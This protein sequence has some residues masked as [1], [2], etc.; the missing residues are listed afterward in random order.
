LKTFRFS[1]KYV[2]FSLDPVRIQGHLDREEGQMFTLLRNRLGIPGII[3][4]TALVLAMAGGA[5]A[6]KSVIITKLSQIAPGV[7]KQLKKPGPPGTPGAPGAPGAKGDSGVAGP[8]GDPGAPGIGTPGAAGKSVSVTDVSAGEPECGGRG[9]AILEQEGNPASASE[10]C[11]GE[12]GSPWTAGGT[13]PAGATETGVWSPTS[14]GGLIKEGETYFQISF[15]LPLANAPD[16][17]AVK[18]GEDKSAEGCPGVVDGVPTADSGKL[19]VYLA[20]GFHKANLTFYALD[21][22]ASFESEATAPPGIILDVNCSGAGC[23]AW[24]TWA[25]TG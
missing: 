9:G 21:P 5:Y 12:E 22:T 1:F 13:L 3:S 23:L 6:S 15:T 19:C 18:P 8:K 17:V 14:A 25:V 24:G 2:I 11:N 10:L 20:P 4:V 16:F 7:Q